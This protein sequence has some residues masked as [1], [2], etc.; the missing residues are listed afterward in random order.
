MRNIT[1][2]GL[3]RKKSHSVGGATKTLAKGRASVN[4]ANPDSQPLQTAAPDLCL[5]SHLKFECAPTFPL[6]CHQSFRAHVPRAC[7][8]QISSLA[9]PQLY[10]VPPKRILVGP[11]LLPPSLVHYHHSRPTRPP[12]F[13]RAPWK[14]I[15]RPQR[16]RPTP[17]SAT[18]TTRQGT[19]P[20][21]PL[22]RTGVK[23]AERK[24]HVHKVAKSAEALSCRPWSWM[25]QGCWSRQ[26]RSWGRPQCP[27]P[28]E[29]WQQPS[30]EVLCK[31]AQPNQTRNHCKRA[32]V[33]L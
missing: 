3:Q 29:R 27:T 16:T 18:Y 10:S 33:S 12:F 30:G 15:V 7:V 32:S 21:P 24:K 8:R 6:P 23:F 2:A 19:P 31:H 13:G 5:V 28:L 9:H 1:Q 4:F 25:C 14:W 11:Q 20:R 17:A 22:G 26:K